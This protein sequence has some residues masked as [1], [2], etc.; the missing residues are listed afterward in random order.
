MRGMSYPSMYWL[1]DN[2]V[3]I[4]NNYLCKKDIDLLSWLG[5]IICSHSLVGFRW[6]GIICKVW[7]VGVRKIWGFRIVVVVINIIFRGKMAEVEEIVTNLHKGNTNMVQL[8]HFIEFRII[9]KVI[10]Y[11]QL[12]MSNKIIKNRLL[13]LTLNQ[14]ILYKINHLQL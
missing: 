11:I 1:M 10:E 5:V 12:I 14:R 7:S 8:L 3:V 9:Q 4:T 6:R 13:S 2:Q